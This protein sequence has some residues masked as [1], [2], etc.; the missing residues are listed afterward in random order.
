MSVCCPDNIIRVWW[1]PC[2]ICLWT[3]YWE[4]REGNNPI[5][6]NFLTGCMYEQYENNFYIWIDQF[7]VFSFCVT[8]TTRAFF[9]WWC[10]RM[11]IIWLYLPPT[12]KEHSAWELNIFFSPNTLQIIFEG[13]RGNVMREWRGGKRSW[14]SISNSI[15]CHII[16]IKLSFLTWGCWL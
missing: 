5:I 16:W 7:T 9:C 15:S 12:W 6:S 8:H 2:Y 13:G 4:R 14:Q 10:I 11:L 3:K 1:G